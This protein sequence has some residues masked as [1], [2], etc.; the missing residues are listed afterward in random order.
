MSRVT[1]R[2]AIPVGLLVIDPNRPK[3]PV[4]RPPPTR[5]IGLARR[6]RPGLAGAAIGLLLVACVGLMTFA[7]RPVR[8]S[9]TETAYFLPVDPPVATGDVASLPEEEGDPV[10]TRIELGAARPS[11][12][13]P[14]NTDLALI[15]P[16][17]PPSPQKDQC[18]QFGTKINFARKQSVAFDR[19]VREQ[20]LVMVLHL[21]GIFEDP[22]FT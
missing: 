21:A 9:V 3:S 6:F 4:H 20:K 22:G 11:A 7:L 17:D 2:P 8:Q 5:A 13:A 10:A 12:H 1:L 15:D 18:G 16:T 19:G 14:V